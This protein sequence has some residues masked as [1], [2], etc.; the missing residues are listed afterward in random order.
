ESAPGQN[1]ATPIDPAL[2]QV[3]P[4]G[5]PVL[6]RLIFT[7][8]QSADAGELF[9]AFF[10]FNA[11]A[12]TLRGDT[13]LLGPASATEDGAVIASQDICHG[14]LF[15]GISPVGC[16][17]A[18]SSLITFAAEFGSSNSETALFAPPT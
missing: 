14:G 4:G 6:P 16:A 5:L 1:F 2:V 8:N 12:S 17:N 13:M 10:R 11:Q 18:S 15:A 7:V 9:E 3:T